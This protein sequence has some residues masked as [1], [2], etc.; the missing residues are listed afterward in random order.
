M[1]GT[2]QDSRKARP[3]KHRGKE[4]PEELNFSLPP[5]LCVSRFGFCLSFT[6]KRDAATISRL[7]GYKIKKNSASDYSGLL[8]WRDGSN[9]SPFWQL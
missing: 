8:L 4:G 6:E 2:G 9:A 1:R 7:N 5:F 3:L